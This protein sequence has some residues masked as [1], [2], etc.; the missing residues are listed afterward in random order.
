VI[1]R[2]Q[3]NKLG[4]IGKKPV[5]KTKCINQK[6]KRRKEDSRNLI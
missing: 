6:E 4:L 1:A 3:K 5:K 2:Q